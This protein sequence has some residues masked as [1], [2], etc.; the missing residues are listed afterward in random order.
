MVG[1]PAGGI[2]TF[3]KS[4]KKPISDKILTIIGKA[5]DVR[6]DPSARMWILTAQISRQK[7]QQEEFFTV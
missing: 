6:E 1:V 5:Q 2:G 3:K 7:T 4:P